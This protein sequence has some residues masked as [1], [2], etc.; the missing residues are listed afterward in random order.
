MSDG[1]YIINGVTRVK[2]LSDGAEVD[3]ISNLVSVQTMCALGRISTAQV[4][5]QDHS[6]TFEL[7]D[8]GVFAE[9]SEL[10]I[11]I[12]KDEDLSCIFKGTVTNRAMNL[13]KQGAM[14]TVTARHE[15]FKMTL[16]RHFRCFEDVSDADVINQI[17]GEYGIDAQVADTPVKHEKLVQY[18]CSDWDFVNMR[19]E[20][21]G[22][23]L[24]TL[25][26]SIRA[27]KP[28]PGADPAMTVQNGYSLIR[29]QIET[30][31]KDRFAKI[32]TEAWNY[33]SQEADSAEAET[34][35]DDFAIGSVENKALASQIGNDTQTIHLLSGQTAPDAMEMLGKAQ[36]MRNDLSKMTG[37]MTAAGFASVFPLDNVAVKD[38]GS[39]F[40]GTALVS[41]VIQEFSSSGWETT[42]GLGLSPEPF[43]ER[44]SNIDSPA[45]DG[46]MPAVQGLQIGVV[47]ALAGDPQSEERIRIKLMGTEDASI[48]ARVAQPDAGDSRG[49]EFMPEIGDEVVVGF[50]G[51]NPSEGVVLGMLHSSGK[52]SPIE[53]NDDN[54]IKG[55]VSRE[56]LRLEFDDEG[57]TVTIETPGGNSIK[58]SDDSKGIILEDQNGNKVTLDQNG[59]SLESA[60]DVSIKAKGD[61]NV[62][63][64]DI[65]LKANA[66]LVAKGSASSEIS[67]GGNT[68][69]KGA[70]VQIN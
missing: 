51:G 18:N 52:S 12:G 19:V 32:A 15:A 50:L 11:Q 1:S 24:A 60:K 14:F 45:S 55:I 2:V 67:S 25:P 23:L 57:K 64:V 7:S 5:F 17:C 21:A 38:V 20:T 47:D 33:S 46:I 10:E 66:Q 56:G 31:G 49:F 43:H 62:E 28:D 41:S 40:S 13:S 69:V 27:D 26:G 4:T 61:V 44:F 65:N 63:G 30:N 22:L 42:L 58:V 70:V 6:A 29:L 59:I 9:G 68:V 37:K 34:G 35:S 39:P 8:S 48:W 3:C 36:A 16:E 53:K 54:N